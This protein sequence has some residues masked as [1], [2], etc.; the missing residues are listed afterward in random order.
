MPTI[1]KEDRTN[2]KDTKTRRNQQ[3]TKS[4]SQKPG[5][6]PV[7]SALFAYMPDDQAPMNK[8]PYSSASHSPSHLSSRV[9]S[10]AKQSSMVISPT[11]NG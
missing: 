11:R 1:R 7:S 6:E 10:R 8:H 5:N 9:T 2:A 4:F 3:E